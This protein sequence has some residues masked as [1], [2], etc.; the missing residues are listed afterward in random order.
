MSPETAQPSR[1]D[2]V[3]SIAIELGLVDAARLDEAREAPAFPGTGGLGQNLGGGS[4]RCQ[5]I[6][7]LVGQVGG[8]GF[9]KPQMLLDPLGQL[10]ERPG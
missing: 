3:G 6:L 4:D 1:D 5:G 10:L 9:G 2:M 7:E 8:E